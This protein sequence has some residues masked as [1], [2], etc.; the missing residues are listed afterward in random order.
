M[1]K[2][3]LKELHSRDDIWQFVLQE[4][5]SLEDKT[6]FPQRQAFNLARW[7]VGLWE[8]DKLYWSYSRAQRSWGGIRRAA[9]LE[10]LNRERNAYIRELSAGG[11]SVRKIA[12]L[13]DVEKSQVCNIINEVSK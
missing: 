7:A 3:G 4:F 9:E 12:A 8:D 13:V 10:K 1:R 5:H 6:D 2:L 11:M